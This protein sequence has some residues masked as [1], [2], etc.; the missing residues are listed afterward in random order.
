MSRFLDD[1]EYAAENLFVRDEELRFLA[2][3]RAFEA[4]AAWAT[5]CIS[6]DADA[7]ARYETKLVDA[8][9]AGV[10]EE[11]ILMMVQTDLEHAGK[12][13][14]STTAMTTLAQ[15]KAQAIDELHGRVGP[16][17]TGPRGQAKPSHP[18]MPR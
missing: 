3:R 11:Q 1:R 14:L 18:S 5:E 9:L 10:R 4:L 2:H 8:F 12:P 16:R 6:L 15:A 17:P 7:A 13:A